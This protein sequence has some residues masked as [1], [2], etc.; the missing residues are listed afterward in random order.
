MMQSISFTVDIF[1]SIGAVGDT[2]QTMIP[3]FSRG[4]ES[5]Q[6]QFILGEADSASY[7]K[8]YIYQYNIAW[9]AAADFTVP[10][11]PTLD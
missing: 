2:S 11:P 8:K 10:S 5:Q 4:P 1:K 7:S 9:G 6:L 3:P